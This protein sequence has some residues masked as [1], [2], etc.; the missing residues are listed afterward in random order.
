MSCQA[1][2]PEVT[3]GAQDLLLV[4]ERE[5]SSLAWREQRV[6]GCLDGTQGKRALWQQLCDAAL[7]GE[8]PCG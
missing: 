8:W 4:L 5:P 1:W 6:A 2:N 3:P 7:V